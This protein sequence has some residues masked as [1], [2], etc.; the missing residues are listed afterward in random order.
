MTVFPLQKN[1]RSEIFDTRFCA[2]I[3][4]SDPPSWWD[5]DPE[6]GRPLSTTSFGEALQRRARWCLLLQLAGCIVCMVVYC[7]VHAYIH[8]NIYIYSNIAYVGLMMIVYVC[9]GYMY[10]CVS[11]CAW[12]ASLVSSPHRTKEEERTG[13]KTKAAWLKKQTTR[14]WWLR[15]FL[16]VASK[17]ATAQPAQLMSNLWKLA[18]AVSWC[19]MEGFWLCISWKTR[20]VTPNLMAVWESKV[21]NPMP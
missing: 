1:Q 12:G 9:Y 18:T 5:S 6:P 11:L 14:Q 16:G 4:D 15:K 21:A 8:T 19:W 3:S 20:T 10:M 7:C 13:N 2:W 17:V